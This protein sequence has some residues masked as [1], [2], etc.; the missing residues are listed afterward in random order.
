LILLVARLELR[1]D[2]QRPR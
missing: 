2:L 1:R